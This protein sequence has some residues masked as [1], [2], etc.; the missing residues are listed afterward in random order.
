MKV[1]FLIRGGNV[2]AEKQEENMKEWGGYTEEL[3]KKGAYLSGLPLAG[4]KVVSTDK[5][6]DYK[7]S[8]MDIA[9]YYELE[10]DSMENAVMAAQ[11]APN[12]KHG[13]NIEIREEM[14][15]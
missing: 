15:M 1:L 8:D 2:P 4:G 10:V 13:G 5:V 6:K 12:I 9:G 7:S 14:A 3:K 11:M